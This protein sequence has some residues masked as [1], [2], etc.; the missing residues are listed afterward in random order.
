MENTTTDAL[1]INEK[2]KKISGEID[3]KTREITSIAAGIGCLGNYAAT[4]GEPFKFA[5]F[6]DPGEEI[7][8]LISI[9]GRINTEIEQLTNQLFH[10]ADEIG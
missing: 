9:T 8:T 3:I 10:L 2:I 5:G 6:S 1:S 7:L 4:E